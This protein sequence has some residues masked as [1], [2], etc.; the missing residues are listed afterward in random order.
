LLSPS[1]SPAVGPCGILAVLEPDELAPVDAPVDVAGADDEEEDEPPPQPATA[2]ATTTS[3]PPIHRRLDLDVVVQLIPRPPRSCVPAWLNIPV[4]IAR[5]API[6]D[7]VVSTIPLGNATGMRGRCRGWR[8]CRRGSRCGRGRRRGGRDRGR[9]RRA[10]LR[11]R[12]H[13]RRACSRSGGAHDEAPGGA[14]RVV[15]GEHHH[16]AMRPGREATECPAR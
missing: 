10:R 9:R 1:R 4:A 5:A 14:Y 16:K 3:S 15:G 2:S 6:V 7:I 13:R 12:R 8:R 11:N